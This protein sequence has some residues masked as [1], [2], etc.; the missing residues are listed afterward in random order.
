MVNYIVAD[1]TKN[2]TV[3]VTDTV[4][5]EE[6]QAVTAEIFATVPSCEQVGYLTGPELMGFALERIEMMGGEFCG[7][8]C[9]SLAAYIAMRDEITEPSE[10]EIECSG[11]DK[12]ICCLIR[13]VG[14]EGAHIKYEGRLEMPVP[15][16]IAY[17]DSHPVIFLP[18]IAHMIMPA[19]RF[20]R[21]QVENNIR[22]YAGRYDVE[23]FGILLWDE[24]AKYMTPCV[25]VKGSDTIVW[26]NGCA[27]GSTCIGWH[28]YKTLGETHTEVNQPGGTIK[29][30]I[31]AERPFMTGMVI[32]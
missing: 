11:V 7:N 3:L 10:V 16:K 5:L 2:I 20:T 26:E 6:R 25:Y 21:R 31:N 19:D 32:I 4:P 29:I 1:P 18:G 9:L 28:R 14:T 30:D 17:C 8:A 23:A 22:E 12:T 24:E 13:Q 27:T 15:E